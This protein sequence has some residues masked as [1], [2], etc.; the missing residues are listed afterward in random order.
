MTNG[1]RGSRRRRRQ[2]AHRAILKWLVALLVVAATG[3]YAYRTGTRLSEVKIEALQARIAVLSAKS[4]A[5]DRLDELQQRDLVE[6]LAR[7]E[8]WQRRYERDVPTGDG[9]MLAEA[10][11]QKLAAGVSPQRL[12]FVIGAAQEQRDCEDVL[13]AKRL[14]VTTPLH[15]GGRAGAVGFGNGEIVVSAAGA[16]MRDA[17]GNPEAWFDPA[18]PVR[19]DLVALGGQKVEETGVLPLFPSVIVGEAEYRLSVLAGPGRGLAQV[20]VQK[21]RY[22]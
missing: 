19:V 2:N 4:G 3:Y 8:D 15:R 9:K 22:P 6:A 20:S 14:V 18:Q 16:S 13:A 7:A 17:N 11:R 1:L 21:C 12:A 5:L 10:V